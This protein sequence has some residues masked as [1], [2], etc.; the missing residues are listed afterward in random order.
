MPRGL[1]III[2]IHIFKSYRKLYSPFYIVKLPY[3][4]SLKCIHVPRSCVTGVDVKIAN[5]RKTSSKV[6]NKILI[7]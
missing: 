1:I 2:I 4:K 5:D 7:T 3:S 6:I